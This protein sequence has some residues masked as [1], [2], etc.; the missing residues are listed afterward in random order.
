MSPRR[1]CAGL[2]AL[3]RVSDPTS[4]QDELGFFFL[5]IAFDHFYGDALAVVGEQFF[6]DS[7]RVGGDESG[8][9]VEYGLG[10]PVILLQGH[11]LGVGEVVLEAQDVAYVGV[12]PR[13]DGLIR[14]ADNAEVAMF[15]GDYAGY[16]VLGDVGVLKLVNHE[17]D[18]TVLVLL[19]YVRA[20]VQQEVGLEQ[21]G[22]RSPRRLSGP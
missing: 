4:L 9:G 14:V 7:L 13:V 15:L 17:V 20:V 21:T 2:P 10:G 22:R 16:G 1:Y 5:V 12:S 8:S 3:A 11:Y 19:G 18:E 6:L